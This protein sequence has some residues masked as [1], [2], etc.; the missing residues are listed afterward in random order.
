MHK[1]DSIDTQE[2]GTG[3]SLLNSSV[4]KCL[5]SSLNYG[6]SRGV[7]RSRPVKYASRRSCKASMAESRRRTVVTASSRLRSKAAV[8]RSLDRIQAARPPKS[9][10]AVATS[11]TV[12]SCIA[13]LFEHLDVSNRMEL[14]V[15]VLGVC[16]KNSR[17]ADSGS[18]WR[19]RDSLPPVLADLHGVLLRYPI[20]AHRLEN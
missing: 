15:A 7:R 9:T 11:V 5:E 17:N 4:L 13:L 12:I 1:W 14:I 18:H 8:R 3:A 2:S 20:L 6:F 19:Q 10:P 16:N